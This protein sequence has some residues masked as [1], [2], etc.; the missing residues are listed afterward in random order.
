MQD[1][2]KN[3]LGYI[4]M[5]NERRFE[6]SHRFASA[7]ITFSGRT[8]S[9]DDYFGGIERGLEVVPDFQWEIDNVVVEGEW[10][11]SRVIGTGT[12]ISEWMGCQP[13]GRP[14]S[15]IEHAFYHCPGGR[16]TKVDFV[17]DVDAIRAQLTAR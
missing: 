8:M 3:Y 6:M 7:E 2:K 11:A 1:L 15:F 4:Q 14:V 16:I 10:L 9:R 12:P 5:I 13:T 17:R